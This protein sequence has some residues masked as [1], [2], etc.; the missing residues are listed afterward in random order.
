MAFRSQDLCKTTRR[1]KA[2][3]RRRLFPRL[4]RDDRLLPRLGMA[5]RFFET[6]LGLRRCDVDAEAVAHLF[7]EPRLARCLVACLARSYR[8]RA[9]P[10]SEIIGAPRAA[11]L[12]ARGLTMPADLRALAYSH[13]ND[14]AGFVPPAERARFLAALLPDL[15]PGEI[16][17][18]LWLDA[19][20]QAVLVRVG[21]T[22]TPESVRALYN[23]RVLETLLRSAEVVHLTTRGDH[24]TVA[25]VC[26]RHDVRA[27]IGDA[28]VTLHGERDALGVWNRHGARLARAALTML[29]SDRLGPGEAI[30]W[31]GDEAFDVRLDAALLRDALPGHVWSAAPATWAALD[32]L[33]AALAATRRLGRLVGWRV[34]RWPEP[35]VGETGVIWPEATLSRG[36]QSVSLLAL[37]GAEVGAGVGALAA[38]Q[39][40]VVLMPEGVADAPPGVT[41]LPLGVPDAAAWLADHLARAFPSTVAEPASLWLDEVADAARAAGSLAESELARRLD[42]AE[43]EVGARLAVLARAAP[44]LVYIDGFGLCAAAFLDQAEALLDRETRRNDGRLDLSALGRTLRVLAGRNEGLHA[45]IAHLS[46]ELRPVA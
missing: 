44:D 25:A 40:L 33:L 30:V 12:A 7:D 1:V 36:R 42:C 3:G 8:Y 34:R 22:P 41:P 31:I 39:P 20:D 4:L 27:D 38:R 11:A 6:N 13:A 19:P 9:R 29:G 43:E 24:A 35:L 28:T 15:D 17:Q 21:P 45:L 37:T 10:L 2:G 18:A 5:I 16:E 26:E 14:G 32:D 23:A 46:G